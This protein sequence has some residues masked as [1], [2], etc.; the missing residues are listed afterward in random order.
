[1]KEVD[2]GGP[3]DAQ[4]KQR[5]NQGPREVK[6]IDRPGDQP[7]GQWHVH[8]KKGGALNKDGS[9]REGNPKFSKKVLKWLREHGWDT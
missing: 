9:I 8:D 3:Q 7:G 1:M 4:K 5:K 2:G 6:R